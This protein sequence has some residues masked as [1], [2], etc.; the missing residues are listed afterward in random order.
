VESSSDQ[1]AQSFC[2][3]LFLLSLNSNYYWFSSYDVQRYSAHHSSFGGRLSFSGLSAIDA[4]ATLTGIE[5]MIF[6]PAALLG[7]GWL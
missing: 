2:L 3:C 4:G 5:I 7:K 1:E 6:T